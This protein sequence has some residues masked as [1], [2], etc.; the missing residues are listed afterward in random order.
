[1]ARS[2]YDNGDIFIKALSSFWSVVYQD[3]ALLN[4][5]MSGYGELFSDAYFNFLESILSTS[6]EDIPVF[7]KKKWYFLSL[8]ESENLADA[9]LIYTKEGIRYGPQPDN[10]LFSSNTTFHYGGNFNSETLFRWTLP[11]NIVDTDRFLMNRIHSPSLVMTKNQE[12]IIEE[13]EGQKVITFKDNPFEDT[14]IPKRNIQDSLGKTVDREFGLWALNTFW[15]YELVWETYGKLVNFYRPN[16]EEYKIFVRAIWDLFVG[17]PNF[18]NVEAGVN[19]VLGLPITRDTETIKEIIDDGTNNVIRTDLNIYKVDKSIPLRSD[20]FSTEGNLIPDTFEPLTEVISVKDSV[21]DPQW[22][23]DIDPFI[24]PKNLIYENVDFFIPD[25]VIFYADMVIGKEYGPP[26]GVDTPNE[27]LKTIGLRIGEWVIGQEDS[28]TPLSYKLDYKNYI[29]ENFFKENLFFLSISPSVTQLQNFDRQVV[30]VIDTIIDDY[31]VDPNTTGASFSPGGSTE[32][33]FDGVERIKGHNNEVQ[34][35][36]IGTGIPLTDD[37]LDKDTAGYD[38]SLNAG[39]EDG[40]QGFP[41]LGY[42]VIGDFT[43]GTISFQGGLLVRSVC[44]N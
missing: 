14:R 24:I 37:T 25:N 6:I 41:F 19:A 27:Y 9:K 2:G 33:G 13:F 26:A 42:V 15:D 8:K 43:I 5:F 16:S 36:D 29:M 34:V 39:F 7:N 4:K 23:N 10:S 30:Q 3:R 28:S 38:S 22:W 11:R 44:G 20:F 35:L 17:G 40:F 32:V 31:T 1:M 18:K 12:F 21:S